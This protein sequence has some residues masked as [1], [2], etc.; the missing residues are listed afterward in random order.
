MARLDSALTKTVNE[1]LRNVFEKDDAYFNSG[2]LIQLHE[3][4]RVSF[5]DRFGDTFR[6]K[7]ENVSTLE[8][9][10]ILNTFPS[11]Q[12]CTVYG[13]NI[14]NTEGKAG[15]AAIKLKESHKFNSKKF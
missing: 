11:I 12:M 15:M 6:W 10:S 1:I 5:A 4:H 8:V 3:D 9:E 7:G 13:I 14:P 2:D